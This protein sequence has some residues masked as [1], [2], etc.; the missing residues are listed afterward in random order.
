LHQGL[1]RCSGKETAEFSKWQFLRIIIFT[2]SL[3][4]QN[5]L[6]DPV[7]SHVV[8]QFALPLL[9]EFQRTESAAFVFLSKD[10]LPFRG[11]CLSKISAF[12]SKYFQEDQPYSHHQ[13]TNNFNII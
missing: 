2:R 12:A 11:F 10:R 1:P 8:K 7:S 13:P 5:L 6:F 3:P 9:S 4:R